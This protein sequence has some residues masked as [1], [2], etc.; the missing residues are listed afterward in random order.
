[1]YLHIAQL[2]AIETRVAAM[3][4]ENDARSRR[5]E[6]QAYAEGS[7]ECAAQDAEEVGRKIAGL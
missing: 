6:A 7:F 3:Q 1:M 5:G 4:A 2:V